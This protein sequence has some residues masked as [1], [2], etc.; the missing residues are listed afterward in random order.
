MSD[1]ITAQ[2]IASEL[3][4]PVEEAANLA[5]KLGLDPYPVNYW[6]VDHDEMNELIA[7]DGFQTRDRKSVV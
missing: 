4:S 6:I 3:E 7:Y 2:R 5:K 1:R